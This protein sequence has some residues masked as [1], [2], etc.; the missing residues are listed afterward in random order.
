MAHK[1][2]S[3]TVILALFTFGCN[4]QQKDNGQAE[5]VAPATADHAHDENAHAEE[6]VS[7]TTTV[8][9]DNGKR[10]KANSETTSGIANMVELIDMQTAKPGDAKAMKAA[11]EEEFGL[12]FERCTMTGEAHNQ[13]HN[14]LIPV[15][16]QLRGM[17]PNK[18]ED[19]IAM[20]TY[21][22][23]YNTSFE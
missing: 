16:D 11:L 22:E 4:E 13:L 14:F 8:T 7:S 6:G 17:D 15:Y 23:L 10:W 19:L 20:K 12:I 3:I 21:L 18:P 5:A 1:L 9:L 2:T